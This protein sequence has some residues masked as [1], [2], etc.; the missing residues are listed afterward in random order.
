[1]AAAVCKLLLLASLLTGAAAQGTPKPPPRQRDARQP[2]AI[3][4]NA[5]RRERRDRGLE[6]AA[7]QGFP[8]AV[9]QLGFMHHAGQGMAPSWRRAREYYERAIELGNLQAVK[10]MQILTDKIQ[11]VTSHP[12]RPIHHPCAS[13]RSL[14]HL[15]L[16]AQIA[17][18]MDKRV[19]IHGTSRAD[20]NGKRGVAADFHED[21][22]RYAVKLDSGEA[23]KFKPANVRA[24][25]ADE[26][27]D[28]RANEGWARLLTGAGAQGTPKPPPRQRDAR[29]P[30][31]I[32]DNAWRRERREGPT[33]TRPQARSSKSASTSTCECELK[34]LVHQRLSRALH[35]KRSNNQTSPCSPLE[36]TMWRGA[37]DAL[38]DSGPS[39]RGG[40]RLAVLILWVGDATRKELPWL[41]V[42]TSAI[43]ARGS[44]SHCSPST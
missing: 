28:E 21:L 27:A 17:P 4:D 32:R 29:Q 1:M 34:R 22:W 23:L 10:N 35:S 30:K 19:E 31:A 6:R 7:V 38:P 37:L 36:S 39:E 20:M 25:G 42:S 40:V 9:N 8:E 15:L 13:P 2:K 11:N 41:E 16:R 5:W 14:S 12:L 26:G 18:L 33:R 43:E 3:R 44:I 24:E